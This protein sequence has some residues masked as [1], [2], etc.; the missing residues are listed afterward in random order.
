MSKDYSINTPLR[1][2]NLWKFDW[3]HSFYECWWGM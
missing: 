3:L 1:T 2:S